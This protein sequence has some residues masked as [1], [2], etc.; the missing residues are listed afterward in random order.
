MSECSLAGGSGR[1]EQNMVHIEKEKSSG[2]SPVP[3]VDSFW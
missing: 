3:Q 1:E 2:F